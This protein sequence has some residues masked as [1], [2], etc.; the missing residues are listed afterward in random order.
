MPTLQR[1][2]CR[3]DIDMTW[4]PNRA[5]IYPIIV[6]G[7]CCNLSFG[8]LSAAP[9]DS[10]FRSGLSAYNSGDFQKA[11]QIWLPLAEHEDAPS[12]AGLGFMYYRGLGT[13]VD[14]QKAAFW[15]RK[16]AEHGQPEGQFM[17]GTL[18]FYGRG[19]P[20]SYIQAYAWCDLAQDGGD[21][22]A[23]MCRDSSLQ[24]L[25][26]NDDLQNAFRLS[27]DFHHRFSGQH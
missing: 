15:L 19:V 11:M 18:Y 12:Q 27:Q 17:L 3:K 13:V 16:A 8:S 6:A 5:R 14:N 24:S 20:Q 9:T 26:S 22:D 2:G 25:P 4:L 1:K 21:A 7:I 23:S 10:P